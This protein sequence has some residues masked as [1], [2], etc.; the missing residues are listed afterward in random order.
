M[1]NPSLE[2]RRIAALIKQAENRSRLHKK[3]YNYQADWL[4]K[5][6]LGNSEWLVT[7][8]GSAELSNV[9]FRQPMPD[10][11]LLTDDCNA[12]LLYTAQKW[13]FHCRMGSINGKAASPK[14]WT[15]YFHFIMNLS[16]WIILYKATYNPTAY[17]FMQLTNDAFKAIAEGLSKGGWGEALLYKERFLAHLSEVLGYLDLQAGAEFDA[18]HLPQDFIEKAILYF[19]TQN[20]YVT[21]GKNSNYEKG[22][23]SREFLT[24]VLGRTPTSFNN[25]SFRLFIRQFEPLLQDD[26][27]LHVAIQRQRHTTQNTQTIDEVSCGGITAPY[28]E[29]LL[30]ILQ[31]FFD[32]HERLPNEI[33]NVKVDINELILQYAYN[34]KSSGHTKLIHFDI[35]FQC[36]NQAAMWV[37]VYGEAIVSSLDFYTPK[38][39]DID[40][41]Y[42]SS[43]RSRK[44]Q[45]LFEETKYLWTTKEMDGLPSQTLVQALNITRLQSKT[46]HNLPAGEASYM[47]AVEAFYGACAIII[48]MLKPI[49]NAELS[50]LKRDCLS[51]DKALGGAF[52]NHEAGKTGDLGINADIE[53]PIPYLAAHAIQLLQVLGKS[54]SRFYGDVSEHSDDL[55]YLPSRGFMMPRLLKNNKWKLNSCTNMFCDLIRIPLDKFGRRWYVRVHEMRKFFLLIVH[56][57][58]GDSSKELLRY[59][60]GQSNSQHINDYTAYD[61][62]DSEA[63]RY[64]SE[65]IDDKLIA[66]EQGLL[67]EGSNQGLVAVYTK[68]LKHFKA[69]SISTIKHSEFLSYLDEVIG[70]SD[71]DLIIYKVYLE[72]Y[73]FKISTIDF[74]IKLGEKADENYNIRQFKASS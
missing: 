40:L 67:P 35:G 21:S 66:L 15:V 3:N 74:A 43:S 19:E 59:T 50:K 61:I 2:E 33:P 68:V 65:F 37:T 7:F 30:V 1:D 32:E 12:K 38:F 53:R 44:K 6:E 16:A 51:R 11:T 23:L 57:H 14:R 26:N 62:S 71:F 20:L 72:E 34:F 52:I 70:Q 17:G 25:R 63:I 42:P 39:I 45:E 8:P 49:R 56:R 58:E 9:D 47:M 13:L 31:Q 28:F 18:D 22:I 10:G 64:E 46:K 24:K 55:F 41:R 54:L 69:T 27:L 36:L 48:G 4:V 73:D 29:D 60:A 5:G